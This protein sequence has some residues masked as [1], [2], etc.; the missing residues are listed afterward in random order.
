M[1]T[2]ILY[3]IFSTLVCIGLF[4]RDNDW[5]IAITWAL[6]WGWFMFPIALGIVLYKN[7]K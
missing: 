3:Y 5:F 4:W 2:L 6:I 1:I 7:I